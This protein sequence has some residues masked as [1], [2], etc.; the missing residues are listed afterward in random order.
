MFVM[1]SAL[2]KVTPLAHASFSVL[3]LLEEPSYVLIKFFR[4][5]A[6]SAFL[7][8]DK[9]SPKGMISASSSIGKSEGRMIGTG[10]TFSISSRSFKLSRVYC[11]YRS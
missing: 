3:L 6:I 2:P 5:I 8:A 10:G 11:F 7:L 9:L 1:D 4:V